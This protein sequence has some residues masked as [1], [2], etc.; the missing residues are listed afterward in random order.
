MQ[1]IAALTL[2]G[3]EQSAREDFEQRLLTLSAVHSLLTDASW[4]GA[5]LHDVIR[6]SLKT[7][8]GGG[9]ERLSFEGEDFRLRPNSAVAL[10]M[11]MHELATNALKYGALSA[12][13]GSVTVGWT[14]NGK[15]FRLRWEESGGPAVAPPQRRGFGSRMIEQGLSSAAGR[16]AHRP[17]AG[18]R[19]LYHRR[20][21][22]RD[23]RRSAKA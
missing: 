7:H 15:R 20:A 2:R 22:Q 21:D 14:T 17:S 19:G 18:R 12:E 6:A 16:G 10:S 13:R 8:L 9:H 11:A 4:D 3:A 23:P 1:S 5:Q